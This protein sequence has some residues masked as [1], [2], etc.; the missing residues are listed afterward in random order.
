MHQMELW[1]FEWKGASVDSVKILHSFQ[2]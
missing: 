2:K 1:I